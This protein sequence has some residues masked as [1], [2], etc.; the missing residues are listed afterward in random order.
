[1]TIVSAASGL[2]FYPFLTWL[3]VYRLEWGAAGAAVAMSISGITE[4][5][6]LVLCMVWLH[7]QQPE[8]E[9]TWGGLD[10]R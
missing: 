7:R 2:G 5:C 9:K 1:M 10:L 4:S 3:L 6:A 8:G